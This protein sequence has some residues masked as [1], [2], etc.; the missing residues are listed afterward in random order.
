MS[1][2]QQ[3][4]VALGPRLKAHRES[5]GITLDGLAASTKI[6]ASLFAE[7]EENNVAHWPEGIYRR[8]WLRAYLIAI[9]MPPEPV[10]EELARLFP[11]PLATSGAEQAE[12]ADLPPFRL[13]FAATGRPRAPVTRS[14]IMD[15]LLS[16]ML[17]LACG[18]VV[19]ALSD[20]SFW[21]ASGTVALIWYPVANAI[22]GG[23]SPRGLLRS[24]ST[25]LR[26]V[27]AVP[28]QF[29]GVVLRRASGLC[30]LPGLGCRV[31]FFSWTSRIGRVS[32]LSAPAASGTATVERS[33]ETGR[34]AVAGR[35]SRIS[36]A[37]RSPR[38]VGSLPLRFGERGLKLLPRL[39]A[40]SSR[41]G[42]RRH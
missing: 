4:D 37:F 33:A 32:G 41:R 25:P 23:A 34:Q 27:S 24:W 7:L 20:S 19:V 39:F 38:L 14:R 21:T 31:R 42:R 36:G 1:H 26:T 15:A 29:T 11:A 5:R 16:L 12:Q 13:T 9:G 10:L 28:Q 18:G 40:R 17:V 35:F 22:Y 3:S 30:G 6:K 2:T 8:A